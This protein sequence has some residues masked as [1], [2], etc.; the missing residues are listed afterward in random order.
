MIVADFRML[1]INFRFGKGKQYQ[2]PV[3]KTVEEGL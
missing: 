2:E 3:R 1:K